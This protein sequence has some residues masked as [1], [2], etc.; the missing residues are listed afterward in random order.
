MT[1]YKIAHLL[2]DRSLGGVTRFL[3][4]FESPELSSL[5]A[6]ILPDIDLESS[7]APK[8][9][10]D[11][12]MTH[13]SANWRRIPFLYS[14]RLRNPQ[15][16]IIHV[17]HSY[18]PEWAD[19]HVAN[20]C[21]FR[22]MLKTAYAIYDQIV[23]VSERQRD[24][25]CELGTKSAAHF[26]VIHPYALN[27]GLA[28]LAPAEFWYGAKITI[29][30]YGRFHESKGFDRLIPAFKSLPNSANMRLLIGGYGEDEQQL[31]DL[32][33]GCEHIEFVGQ[34]DDVPAFLEQCEIVAIPSRYETF[35]MVAAEAREAGRPIIVSH[36]GG[37]P[38]QAGQ[39]GVIIDGDDP[40]HLA[41]TLSEI[42]KFPLQD[43][44]YQA[45]KSMEGRQIMTIRQWQGLLRQYLPVAACASHIGP[46]KIPV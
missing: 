7:I 6:S 10:A 18:S 12:I 40:S 25:L 42:R 41:R 15:A 2:D 35:G 45:K 44:A 4:I 1:Q 30:A 19:L 24:W 16:K 27:P 20:M 28:R 38:E 14:L 37:L 17:E 34:V 21:R 5:A 13:F 23:A 31:R 33:D 3:E 39:S 36:V 9:D 22:L 11:I 46:G 29:G 32:A 43:M 26:D 8:V